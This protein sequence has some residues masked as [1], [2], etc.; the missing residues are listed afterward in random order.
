MLFYSEQVERHV[1]LY[2]FQ[3]ARVSTRMTCL[4][5][6]LYLRFSNSKIKVSSQ[7]TVRNLFP[8]DF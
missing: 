1:V 7:R 5:T 6:Q 8:N 3:L 4:Q 2:R